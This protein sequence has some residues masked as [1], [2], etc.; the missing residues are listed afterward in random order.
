METVLKIHICFKNR[1]INYKYY[2]S[3]FV[4]N[5]RGSHKRR[6]TLKRSSY[7]ERK[8]NALALGAEEGRG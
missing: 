8:G 4:E 7:E 2:Y 5:E 3:F 1:V 6:K